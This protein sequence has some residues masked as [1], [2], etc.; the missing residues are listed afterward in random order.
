M[1]DS[2]RGRGEARNRRA[3]T[4][5]STGTRAVQA[6]DSTVGTEAGQS[7]VEYALL[8][9][10][11]AIIVL[12]SVW[13]VERWVTRAYGRVTTA[14]GG[15][16]EVSTP[17]PT[18]TPEEGS[19][20]WQEWREA[21]GSGW[22]AETSRYCVEQQG[23][24]RSFYGAE[25]WTD[26]IIRVKADLH[27]G[28]GYGVFFRAVDVSHVSGYVFQYEPTCRY[29][30]RDGCF[31]FRKVVGGR[32]EYPFARSGVPS[33][34]EWYDAARDIEVR[35]EGGSFRAFIDGEEVLLGTDDEYTHGQVGLRTWD[36]SEVCFWGFT[37]TFLEEPDRDRDD[38]DGP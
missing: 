14:V 24:H 7:L 16:E 29:L 37:I 30:G 21:A 4:L 36:A 31:S 1:T 22:R 8:L 34:Y 26:Y 12:G 28:E 23:E 25:N 11:I 9:V 33:G 20:S 13:L 19:S 5:G 10:L 38:R 18:A 17:V 15:S 32:V 27:Q 6:A 2:S 3:Y 35:V